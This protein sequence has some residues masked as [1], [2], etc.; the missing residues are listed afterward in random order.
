MVASKYI[1]MCSISERRLLQHRA[2]PLAHVSLRPGADGLRNA[3]N[4]NAKDKGIPN[5]L[6]HAKSESNLIASQS[7]QARQH[8]AIPW[9]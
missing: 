9:Y 7:H 3:N 6:P 2:L 5:L 8:D 4:D 1:G